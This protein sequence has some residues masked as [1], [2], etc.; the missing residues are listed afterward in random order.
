VKKRRTTK[1]RLPKEAIQSI[2][3]GGPMKGKRYDRQQEKKIKRLILE[4]MSDCDFEDWDKSDE[5]ILERKK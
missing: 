4:E 2:G 3:R 5:P 1:P